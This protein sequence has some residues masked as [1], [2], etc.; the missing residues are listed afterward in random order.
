MARGCPR[1]DF[2]VRAISDEIDTEIRGWFPTLPSG[3]VNCDGRHGST[4]AACKWFV[5]R[6]L[7]ILGGSMHRFSGHMRLNAC[8]PDLGIN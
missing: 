5:C 8:K 2:E 6:T 4:F 7:Q 3:F 1:P